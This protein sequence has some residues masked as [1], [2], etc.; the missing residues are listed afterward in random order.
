MF[1]GILTFDTI[2]SIIENVQHWVVILKKTAVKDLKKLP[3]EIV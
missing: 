1:Y 3:K 2:F